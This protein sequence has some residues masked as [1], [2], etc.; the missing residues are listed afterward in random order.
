MRATLLLLLLI[1]A[2]GTDG[3]H[4]PSPGPGLLPGDAGG[5]GGSFTGD[6]SVACAEGDEGCACTDVG[7]TVECKIGP[8]RFGSFVSCITGKSTCTESLSWSRCV[9]DDAIPGP[10]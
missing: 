3:G 1:P 9:S 8:M 5:V 6:G 2:C 10:L 4:A 7:A